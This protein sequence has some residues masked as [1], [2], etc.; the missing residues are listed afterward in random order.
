MATPPQI[1]AHPLLAFFRQRALLRLLLVWL[2]DHKR[3]RRRRRHCS[4]RRHSGRVWSGG[5]KNRVGL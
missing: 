4:T 3:C 1:A 5:R 2:D